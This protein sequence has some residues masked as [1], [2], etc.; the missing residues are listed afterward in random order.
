[1]LE[2]SAARS[3][4]GSAGV[5]AQVR[6]SGCGCDCKLAAQL[7]KRRRHRRG[8]RQRTHQPLPP[9]S[10]AQQP[11][12]RGRVQL[13]ASTVLAA[14]ECVSVRQTNTGAS[15]EIAPKA[16]MTL[17]LNVAGSASPDAIHSK[18]IAQSHTMMSKQYHNTV[19]GRNRL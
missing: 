12:Q 6:G 2:G 4:G 14:C 19:R 3:S 13:G 16:G 1:M 11:R 5:T 7:R 10:L 18:A 9:L 15:A 17:S 8:G